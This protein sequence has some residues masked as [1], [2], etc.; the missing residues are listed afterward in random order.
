ML[1]AADVVVVVNEASLFCLLFE[2]KVNMGAAV[3][4]GG[5]DEKLL[6]DDPPIFSS[7]DGICC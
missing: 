1:V 2:P 4:S 7:V 6:S 3:L 5:F